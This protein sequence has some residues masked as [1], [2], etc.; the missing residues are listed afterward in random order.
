GGGRAGRLMGRGKA[1][2]A[3][4]LVCAVASGRRYGPADLGLAEELARRAALSLDNARLYL[5][6]QRAT[7]M[8]EEVL[9]VVSHDLCTPLSVVTMHT[10]VLEQLG[11]EAPALVGE[12]AAGIRAS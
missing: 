12:A 11:D 9:G 6:A 2:G 7:R 8:R 3:L 4:G 5:D 1:I 10:R